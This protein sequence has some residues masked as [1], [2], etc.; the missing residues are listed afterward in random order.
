MK[1]RYFLWIFLLICFLTIFIFAQ[2]NAQTENS[3]AKIWRGHENS[4]TSVAFSSSGKWI[5]SSSLDGT[6][7]VW[8]TETDKVAHILRSHSGDVYSVSISKD[9]R[10]IASAGLDGR[11][12]ITELSDGK[13]SKVFSDLDGWCQAV[14]FSPDSRRVAV[15]TT[16]GK[17]SVWNVESGKLL[18]TL[19]AK[20]GQF[21]L[22]WSPDGKYLASGFFSISIWDITTGQIVKTLK[23]HSYNIYSLSFSPDGKLL[24]SGSL[25]STAGIWNVDSGE[26]IQIIESKGFARTWKNKI[27]IDPI[28]VPVTAVAF[29]PDGKHLATGGAG[30]IIN[31]WNA[32]NG[33]SVSTMQGHTMSVTDLEFSPDGKYLASSSLDRTIR[34]WSLQGKY[35]K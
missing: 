31:I 9:D 22:A 2:S 13:T 28:N 33:K 18:K 6:V 23:G 11:V 10:L 3:S 32:S 29:S 20:R 19:D 1:N 7:R 4:V 25:D 15:S 16:D 34:L 27:I 17:I 8:N 35:G 21:S 24:A 5:A 26:S 14:S 12:V 30:R